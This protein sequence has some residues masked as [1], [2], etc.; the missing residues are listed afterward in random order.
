M[1]PKII[2]VT[3]YG[4]SWWMWWKTLQP[5]W[6]DIGEGKLSRE[7]PEGEEWSQICRGGANGFF[8]IVLTLGWWIMAADQNTE[9]RT[10]ENLCLAME[11]VEWVL[12]RMVMLIKSQ[13]ISTT[14]TKHSLEDA[15][16]LDNVAVKKR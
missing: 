4:Q 7:V 1:S 11:D 6:R 3:E 9:Q 13:G 8:M 15:T 12:D 2:K 14:G 16:A 10:D 5:K